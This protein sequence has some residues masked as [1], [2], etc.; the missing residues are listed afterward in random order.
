MDSAVLGKHGVSSNPVQEEDPVE[1]I[2]VPQ[3]PVRD[4]EGGTLGA[5][6]EYLSPESK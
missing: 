4:E 5:S 2:A 6:P 1:R 3:R